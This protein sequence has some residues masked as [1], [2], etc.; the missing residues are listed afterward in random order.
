[1]ATECDKEDGRVLTLG[2][3]ATGPFGRFGIH[4]SCFLTLTSCLFRSL[5][6]PVLGSNDFFCG[7][8]GAHQILPGL[9]L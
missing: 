2:R 9:I 5:N 6:L 7:E 3:D 4:P 8:G 1:M